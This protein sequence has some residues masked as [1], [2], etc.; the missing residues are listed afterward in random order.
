MTLVEAVD[1]LIQA[2]AE[3]EGVERDRGVMFA[4]ELVPEVKRLTIQ[5]RLSTR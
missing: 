5:I 2:I 3:K 4:D 1:E